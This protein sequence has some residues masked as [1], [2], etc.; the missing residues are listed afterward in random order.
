[1]RRSLIAVVVGLCLVVG[2][3]V[4][5]R[6]KHHRLHNPII[7]RD[8]PMTTTQTIAFASLGG[9]GS[10]SNDTTCYWRA[11]DPPAMAIAHPALSLQPAKQ[12]APIA[13]AVPAQDGVEVPEEDTTPVAQASL[14]PVGW[15][16]KRS[17]GRG[18]YATIHTW[19]GMARVVAWARERF[20][21]F[22]DE[23]QHLGYRVGPPGCLSSGHM[24]HSKHHWGGACDL[25]VQVARN[26]TRLKLPPNHMDIAKRHGLI[27]GCMWRNPDCGHFEVPVDGQ[28]VA[29][30]MASR[31]YSRRVRRYVSR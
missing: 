24:R 2:G 5:A 21:G 11:V 6:P 17:G 18:G 31:G 25:F 12:S 29:Q 26:R 3:Q 28:S 7:H 22:I 1:M 27:D 20:Q 30:Y 15:Y 8:D 14:S 9:D 23:V 4:E 16:H 13:R 19:Q 10:C